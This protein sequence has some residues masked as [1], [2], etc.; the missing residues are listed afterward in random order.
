MKV[1]IHPADRWGCG[2][3]RLIWP[4]QELQ[5]RG[6]DVTIIEPGDNSKIGGL[7]TDGRLTSAIIPEGDVFVFQR[8]TNI[9]LVDLIQHL[10]RSG[11][12]V[13]VD[14]DDD[15]SCIH[16]KNAAFAMLH[17]R[18][19]RG[20]WQNAVEGCKAASLVTL[21]TPPLA[22]RYAAHG[23]YRVLRNCVPDYYLDIPRIVGEPRRWG[24]AGALYSHPDDVPLLGR[25]A[26]ELQRQGHPI[27]VV[28]DPEGT[29]RALGLRDDPEAT[30]RIDLEHW[31][32]TLAATLDIGVAPLADT[33]FNLAK[34]WLKPLEY[35][36]LGIPW[37]ATDTPEY[38]LLA[39]S[40]GGAAIRNKPA[41]WTAAVRR[42]LTDDV[43]YEEMSQQVRAGA[44]DL[45]ISLHAEAW[46]EAWFDAYN[47]DQSLT[48]RQ[49][50]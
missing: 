15:L 46:W 35:A 7:I 2:H 10:R 42:L 40:I 33:R 38:K 21:S 20:N 3:F 34:S 48:A 25:T 44:S 9:I 32:S 49:A 28:G 50:M 47:L 17:P 16:P 29:G 11:K 8:P 37:V 14:M 1:Q 18:N 13:V 43:F 19:P 45:R 26:N 22:A 24:W 39:T 41:L 31:A 6:Y 23:R 36:A 30:G 5:R 4:A 12:T 27:R